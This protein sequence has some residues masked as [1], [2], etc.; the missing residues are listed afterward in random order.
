[1]YIEDKPEMM[2]CM[3]FTKKFVT[4]RQGRMLFIQEDNRVANLN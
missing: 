1:M 3:V 2:A 4:A